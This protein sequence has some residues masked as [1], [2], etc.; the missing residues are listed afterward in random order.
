MHIDDTE[1]DAGHDDTDNR[2]IVA[3]AE[4]NPTNCSA[5]YQGHTLTQMDI[6]PCAAKVPGILHRKYFS[7]VKNNGL[8]GLG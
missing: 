4:I 5:T 8:T 6:A 7:L 1:N 2:H 3:Q